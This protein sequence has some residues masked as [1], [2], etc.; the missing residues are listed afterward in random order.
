MGERSAMGVRGM[1]ARIGGATWRWQD[2]KRGPS[3]RQPSIPQ[4]TERASVSA[5]AQGHRGGD[6]GGDDN[7]GRAEAGG[8]AH[9]ELSTLP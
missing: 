5:R 7:A 6:I 1:G 8:G 4:V 9:F 3:Q 2:V